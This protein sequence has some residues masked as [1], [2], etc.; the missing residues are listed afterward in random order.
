MEKARITA[1]ILCVITLITVMP[2]NANAAGDTELKG[3]TIGI[4]D[5]YI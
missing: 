5:G 2:I 4:S 3:Y 1:I